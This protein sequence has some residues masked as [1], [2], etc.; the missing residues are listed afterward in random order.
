MT[1][2]SPLTLAFLQHLRLERGLSPHT[3][4]SY[5]RDLGCLAA[6]VPDIA[7]F[8]ARD[9]ERWVGWLQDV[10]GLT[11]RSVARALSAVRT[12]GAWLVREGRR[13]DEPAKL[14]PL[15]RLGRP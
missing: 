4:A 8:G 10:E 13:E 9:L 11:A 14:V 1:R 3:A 5:A 7:A 12:F 15:P 6:F 2:A